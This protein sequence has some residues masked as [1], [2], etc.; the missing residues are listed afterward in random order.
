MMRD[1]NLENKR[2]RETVFAKEEERT[3]MTKVVESLS[4]QNERLQRQQE[5]EREIFDLKV[6]S[7]AQLKDDL[8]PMGAQSNTEEAESLATE[9]MY[10]TSFMPSP[11]LRKF[12]PPTQISAPAIEISVTNNTRPSSRAS[13]AS[14]QSEKDTAT[15]SDDSKWKEDWKIRLN[16][17]QK[18][19]DELKKRE[20]NLFKENSGDQQWLMDEFKRF[21]KSKAED[22]EF[23]SA[24][25]DLR[26]RLSDSELRSLSR[27][28][29]NN[30]FGDLVTVSRNIIDSVSKDVQKKA[31]DKD[32]DMIC[33]VSDIIVE[34]CKLRNVANDYSEA[35]NQGTVEKLEKYKKL[36]PVSGHMTVRK[37]DSISSDHI[38]I[39]GHF[40]LFD[41]FNGWKAN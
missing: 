36:W 24:V 22:H 31:K 21:R 23:L 28:M 9:L 32:N 8:D 30:A 41:F 35:I 16:E 18:K 26:N 39:W 33:L 20:E 3:Y 25:Y 27:T 37:G 7:F 5:E 13:K 10:V 1:V 19:Q 38:P 4:E 14:S 15:E 12:N 29:K 2:L 40:P 34:N 11:A 17:L 6:R